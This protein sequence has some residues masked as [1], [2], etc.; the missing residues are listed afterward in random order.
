M[1]RHAQPLAL[2]ECGVHRLWPTVH[3]RLNLRARLRQVTIRQCPDPT[4]MSKSI[5]CRCFITRGENSWKTI[6]GYISAFVKL[7]EFFYSTASY[8]LLVLCTF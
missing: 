5:D 6:E 7:R 3:I 8:V 2:I 4:E 1:E